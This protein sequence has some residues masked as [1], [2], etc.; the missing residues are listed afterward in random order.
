MFAT[1]CGDCRYPGFSADGRHPCARDPG[2]A[3]VTRGLLANSLSAASQRAYAAGQGSFVSFCQ[4]Y[5][6]QPVPASDETLTYFVGD[7]R[8]RGL[9]PATARLYLAAV[10]RLH[11]QWGRPLPPG[12]PP[13]TDAAIR[14]Y[15][16]RRIMSP[17]RP[18]HPLTVERLCLLKSR[19]SLLLPSVWDQRCIWAACTVAFFAG[20]RSSEYLSADGARGL[21]R[22]DLCI[23]S[24]ACTVRIG[25]TKTTQHGPPTHVLLPA[26]GTDTCSVRGVAQYTTARDAVFSATAPLFLMQDGSA[27]TRH[28]LNACLRTALGSGFS[29]HSLRIGLATSAC[30]AGVP[31]ETIQQ[32][33]RWTSG[34]YHGYIRSQRPAIGRALRQ[35]AQLAASH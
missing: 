30:E 16:Q 29:S 8:R 7:M 32:L 25:F 1:D 3:S 11:L 19:L 13:F 20:L 2:L 22:S 23:T 28:V 9:A 18:R 14:G 26:T 24:D 35:I 4:Q 33:G 17:S 6:L 27:L 21:T 5:G 15:P 34:A 12:L 31:D 10:R